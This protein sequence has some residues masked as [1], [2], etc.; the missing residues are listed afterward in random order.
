MVDE[1]LWDGVNGGEIAEALE[2]FEQHQEVAAHG[3]GAGG[4]CREL[5]ILGGGGVDRTQLVRGEDV[6]EAGIGGAIDG[7]HGGVPN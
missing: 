7:G 2:A 6:F 5:D 3:V 1:R 4:A